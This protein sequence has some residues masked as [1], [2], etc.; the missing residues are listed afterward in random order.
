MRISINKWTRKKNSQT[1]C[2]R[3]RL[4]GWYGYSSTGDDVLKNCIEKLFIERAG[5]MGIQA[6]FTSSDRCD[7]CLVGGGTI[8]GCDTSNIL[9]QAEKIRAPLA[10]FGPGFRYTGESECQLWQPRSRKLFDRA[11]KAGVRGPCTAELLQ[12]YNMSNHVEVIG[13]PAVWFKPLPLPWSPPKSFL[14]I[15][16]RVMRNAAAGREERYAS[17]AE[18]LERIARIVPLIIDRL[19]AEPIFMSFGE[20]QFDSDSEA[21]RELRSKLPER[22]QNAKVLPFSEEPRLNPS[23][24]SQVAYL[25]SERMHPSVFAWLAGRPCV[26]L[27]NQYGKSKDLMAGIGMERYCLRTDHL[28][29]ERYMELF[30]ELMGARESIIAKALKAFQVQKRLQKDF[31][32]DLLRTVIQ[33]KGWRVR[34]PD[35]ASQ[36]GQA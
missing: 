14:A 36:V 30:D 11:L 10:I 33:K 17:H 26:M 22:F 27:E 13:D 15:V 25:I 29:V 8:I 31:V 2:L 7:L 21:A 18:T 23:I 35:F 28:S 34:K 1:H 6:E 12:Q 24:I 19:G 5:K 4:L 20:N 32:D 3:I 16:V 9:Q